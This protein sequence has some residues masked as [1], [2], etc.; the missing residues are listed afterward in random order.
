M[1]QLIDASIFIAAERRRISYDL[2]TARLED[3]D[4][5]IAA[6]TVSELLTGVYQA[7]SVERRVR[8]EA[9]VEQVVQSLPVIPFDLAAARIYA[10][11]GAELKRDGFTIGAHDLQIAATALARGYSVVTYDLR[12]F[13][14][15]PGLGVR[16]LATP[17]RTTD[18]SAN[19]RR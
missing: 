10:R 12:D 15:I 4:S 3:D 8:R 17:P 14:R 11:I 13:S 5:A 18:V 19:R 9:F 6:I 7:D 16:G 1:A 2:V